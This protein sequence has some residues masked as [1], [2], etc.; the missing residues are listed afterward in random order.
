M[1]GGKPF[2]ACLYSWAS[3]WRG[4]TISIR[5]SAHPC[6]R[7]HSLGVRRRM[8]LS[9]SKVPWSLL[10]VRVWA[11]FRPTLPRRVFF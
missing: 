1:G 2:P 5:S 9:G 4:K 3:D 8:R 11:I 10:A 6:S 7:R